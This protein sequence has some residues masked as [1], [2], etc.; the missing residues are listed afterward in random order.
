MWINFKS[1]KPFAIKV[2]VGGINAISGEPEQKDEESRL[3]RLH[4][5]KNG[6]CIQDYVVSPEQPWLDGIADEDGTVRQFVAMPL[7]SGYSVEAQVTGND[8]KG[9]MQIEVTPVYVPPPPSLNGDRTN[10]S[11]NITVKTLTGKI[12][13][14][15]LP[16]SS[17]ICE[18]KE[19]IEDQE[20]IPP[21]QQRLVY[22]GKTLE[23]ERVLDDY[24][25]DNVG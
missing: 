1:S 7:G 3:R 11:A 21:D 16:L 23:D 8:T 10:R 18:I 20:G 19:H 25:I 22:A 14:F 17:T 15:D 4:K 24:G 9:G 12:M 6:K 13:P 5:F 2:I